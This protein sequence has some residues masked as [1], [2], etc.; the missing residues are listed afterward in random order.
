MRE[1]FMVAVGGALGTLGRHWLNQ[2][3][4][5]VIGSLFLSET[6]WPISLDVCWRGLD[7]PLSALKGGVTHPGMLL[8]VSDSSGG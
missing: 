2:F 6:S 4:H 8:S 1:W 5:L 3:S 7:G